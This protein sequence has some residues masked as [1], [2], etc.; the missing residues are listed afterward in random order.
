MNYDEMIAVIQARKEGKK[1][2][3]DR[4]TGKW[5][6]LPSD[7]AFNF[8]SFVYRIKP[9]PEPKHKVPLGPADFPPGTVIRNSAMTADTWQL[10][11]STSVVGVIIAYTDKPDTLYYSAL[12]H[13]DYQR[14][15][16]GGKTWLP[17]YLEG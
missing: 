10:V 12:L 17:C 11:L 7:H 4:Y 5:S 6:P 2:E 9:T 14:S 13:Y 8:S 15:P 16:D 3:F 1:I